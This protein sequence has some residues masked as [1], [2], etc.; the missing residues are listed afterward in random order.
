[1]LRRW[2][3]FCLPLEAGLFCCKFLILRLLREKKYHL[4]IYR[5]VSRSLSAFA[6]ELGRRGGALIY[7]THEDMQINIEINDR[8]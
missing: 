6:N 8:K 4:Y 5:Y 1:M 2:V 7:G 3:F